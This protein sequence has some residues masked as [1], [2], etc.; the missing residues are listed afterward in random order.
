[1]RYIFPGIAR[2]LVTVFFVVVFLVFAQDVAP[3][4]QPRE[5]QEVPISLERIYFTEYTDK[6]KDG[7][8]WILSTPEE[9]YNFYI[10]L[11]GLI[12]MEKAKRMAQLVNFDETVIVLVASRVDKCRF[13]TNIIKLG[14]VRED[15]IRI[16]LETVIREP[17]QADPLNKPYII[18]G[19]VIERPAKKV[20]VVNVTRIRKNTLSR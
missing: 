15:N 16:T 6:F 18:N 4:E 14:R 3:Q 12:G 8:T 5:E 17:C 2:L 1:M 13:D 10:E 9:L 7:D 20:E 11:Q 19:A